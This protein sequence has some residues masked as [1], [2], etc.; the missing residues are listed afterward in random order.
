MKAFAFL[1][2]LGLI[3][4]LRAQTT[5]KYTDTLGNNYDLS[6]L[7]AATDYIASSP[8]GEYTFYINVCKALIYQSCGPGCAACQT[9][10]G[11]RAS[12]GSTN[13]TTLG[14]LAAGG[15]GVTMTFNQGAGGRSSELDFVCTPGG[16]VVI[17]IKKYQLNF[18]QFN[19]GITKISERKSWKTL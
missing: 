3:S 5:C 14:P 11:G 10:T 1:V 9:W 8:N 4:P 7:S 18:N 12:V 13:T 6:S 17:K 15:L 16:G 2:I 19:L